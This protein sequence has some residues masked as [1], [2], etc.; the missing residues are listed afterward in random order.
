[1]STD[2]SSSKSATLPKAASFERST[3]MHTLPSPSKKKSLSKRSITFADLPP[4]SKKSS[5]RGDA[6]HL[7]SSHIKPTL[8]S[9]NVVEQPV[10]HPTSQGTLPPRTVTSYETPY[11]Q[12]ARFRLPPTPLT[13][14]ECWGDLDTSASLSKRQIARSVDGNFLVEVGFSEACLTF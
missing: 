13:D 2:S 8:S 3:S 10:R 9:T 4:V 5:D 11:V 14:P 6:S 12:H 1:M 7:K